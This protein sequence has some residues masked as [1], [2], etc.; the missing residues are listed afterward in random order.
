ML[1]NPD[2][3]RESPAA[4]SMQRGEDPLKIKTGH[5]VEEGHP[6]VKTD[7]KG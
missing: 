5:V 3:V 4:L 2:D 6:N 1:Q 7:V